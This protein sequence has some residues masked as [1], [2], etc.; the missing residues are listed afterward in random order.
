MDLGRLETLETIDPA[1]LAPW[2]PSAF[3]EISIDTDREEASER[4]TALLDTQTRSSIPT[5]R[6]PM[7]RQALQQ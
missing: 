3:A 5:H 2:A 7:A 4:A 6:N 1:T